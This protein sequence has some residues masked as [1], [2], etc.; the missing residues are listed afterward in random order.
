MAAFDSKPVQVFS[1]SQCPVCCNEYHPVECVPRLLRSCGH[2]FCETC[3]TG[4]QKIDPNTLVVR[5]PSCRVQTAVEAGKGV[6]EPFPKNYALL[7]NIENVK[8]A[9]AREA[10]ALTTE[11]CE[12]CSEKQ[13]QFGCAECETKYCEG[14]WGF[15]HK[16]RAHQNHEKVSLGDVYQ[17]KC[18][19]HPLNNADLVC[20]EPSCPVFGGLICLLCEKTAAHK[21]H[22]TEPIEQAVSL[23]REELRDA[24]SR[25]QASVDFA[26]K[27]LV[28]VHETNLLL[29]PEGAPCAL[30]S[31]ALMLD[32]EKSLALINTTFSQLMAA[33]EHRKEVLVEQTE[34]LFK[35]KLEKLEAQSTE[36]ST[37]L[38]RSY[39]GI[40]EATQ[41]LSQTNDRI[42]MGSFRTHRNLMVETGA[43][44]LFPDPVV[45]PLV[46]VSFPGDLIKDINALGILHDTEVLQHR[47]SANGLSGAFVRSID[48]KRIGYGLSTV[49]KF[50]LG[51]DGLLYF[52]DGSARSLLVVGQDGTLIRNVNYSQVCAFALG[53]D[54]QPWVI[55]RDHT[56]LRLYRGEHSVR[57]IQER[58]PFR[59][60]YSASPAHALNH[61]SGLAISPDGHLFVSDSLAHQIFVFQADGIFVS[62]FGSK[63]A[64]DGQFS[65]PSGLSFN[66]EGHLC[67]LDQG[68]RR[69]Q[70]FLADGTFVRKYDSFSA[71]IDFSF[72]VAFGLDGQVFLT[73][74]NQILMH[75]SDGSLLTIGSPGQFKYPFGFAFS[76]DGHLFVLDSKN[77]QI[78]VFE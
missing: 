70:V 55:S 69:I 33:L 61:P 48:L 20:L 40:Q 71:R 37:F 5:C 11:K 7:D 13:A 57:V 3:L 60:G 35:T 41:S 29:R 54:N 25:A 50:M 67:V 18:R 32:H 44:K 52:L 53:P 46:K 62:S 51:S 64:G 36:L 31:D 77:S 63:G 27:T 45:T 59:R 23:K 24:I 73:A 38:S 2:T 56:Q 66:P 1:I 74:H 47:R 22:V 30:S 21:G 42:F 6:A 15:C 65:N 4:L 58:Q 68:N 49:G 8:A 9:A 39:A 16:A 14:C 26:L 43:T 19:D 34:S 75:R 28:K 17:A 10:A 78:L 12:M 72:G 76:S